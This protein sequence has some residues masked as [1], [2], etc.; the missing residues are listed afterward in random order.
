MI[1]KLWTGTVK[2]KSSIDTAMV[3]VVYYRR[4]PKYGKY[5]RKEHK[6]P[7]HDTLDCKA[8]EVVQMLEIPR[9]SK[10]KSKKI[11]AVLDGVNVVRRLPE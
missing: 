2:S 9:I 11:I 7:A 10:T 6:Y 4:H 1:A 8:G 5:I 3:S